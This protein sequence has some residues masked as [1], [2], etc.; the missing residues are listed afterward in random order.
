V[1]FGKLPVPEDMAMLQV[2]AVP[3]HAENPALYSACQKWLEKHPPTGKSVQVSEGRQQN[4][5]SWAAVTDRA[6]SFLSSK[7]SAKQGTPPEY[8][9]DFGK[10]KGKTLREL[11]K[12]ADG[13]NYLFF[14]YD[15]HELSVEI[16]RS[17]VILQGRRKARWNAIDIER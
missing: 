9:L 3:T 7:S 11:L 10:F 4:L 13:S 2:D 15:R 8:K 16:P 14:F 5:L 12:T 6:V 17:F 1:A